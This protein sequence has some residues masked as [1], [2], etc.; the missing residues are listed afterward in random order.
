MP[1]THA[2]AHVTAGFRL[3]LGFT[4]IIQAIGR[5]QMAAGRQAAYGRWRVDAAW[6]HAEVR[7]A[8]AQTASTAPS[9]RRALG[10]RYS[11][12]RG[13]RKPGAGSVARA[14]RRFRRI[15]TT[16]KTSE[17]ASAPPKPAASATSNVVLI[18]TTPDHW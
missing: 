11:P 9:T 3:Y 12:T 7:L 18:P 4:S 10:C 15:M 17:L 8:G 14:D 1:H 5:V 6:K 16:P 2:R 13:G